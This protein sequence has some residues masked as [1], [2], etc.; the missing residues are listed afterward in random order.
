[1]TS[2][3]VVK[4][5]TTAKLKITHP[6]TSMDEDL[7]EYALNISKTKYAEIRIEKINSNGIVFVDG[8][9]K[10]IEFSE[11]HGFSIR[12]I[13]GGMGFYFSNIVNK[14]EIK[15]GMEKAVKMAKLQK[16]NICMSEEKVN[17]AKYEIKGS[18]PEIEEKLNFIK[19]LDEFS[20]NIHRTFYY[21]DKISEKLYMNTD[22]SKIYSKIPHIYT[23]YMITVSNG[24]L[25]QMHREFGNTG[26]WKFIN[27]WK[28]GE[29]LQHDINFLYDLIDKGK[30]AP[31]KGDVILAPYIT[32][33]VAHESCG[34]PFEAD[35]ILGREFAQAGKSYA[36]VNMIGEKFANECISIVD[37]PF[38]SNKYGFYKYDDEGVKARK[39]FLIK[40][41]IINEFLHN[42][43]T[44]FEMGVESNSSARAIYGREPIV[45]MANT[46]FMPGDYSSEELIED[47]KEGVYIATFMEWNIDDMRIN[48]K[49]V[50]EEA[51]LI[52][53]G[54]I[55]EIAYHPSIEISTYD[56]Y[57]KVDGAGKNLEFYPAT[58]GKG[59]PMQ[60]IEV[61]TGGVDLR[62]RDVVIK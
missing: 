44:A 8:E 34:H 4:N 5:K 21:K 31:K 45:R 62:L 18:F 42:R 50:G 11:Q 12:V 43:E 41:G 17:E 2:V 14:K 60:G 1:M 57:R 30:K 49:Y 61:S 6:L 48:Q 59:E 29:K 19:N 33:L 53:N 51:Y 16:N 15:K 7:A 39:R 46:Y 23:Y 24:K 52:K 35:R 47:I 26:G 56:F 55:K 58:C 9:A 54:E 40:N 32:G 27:E 25:E 10:E 13:D 3:N 20:K 36:N 38:L 22:G 37:E 28:A